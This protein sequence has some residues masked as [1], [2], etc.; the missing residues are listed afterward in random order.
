[1]TPGPRTVPMRLHATRRVSFMSGGCPVCGF[2][3]SSVSPADAAVALRTFPRRYR[4]VLVPP[5]EEGE[6]KDPAHR[7]GVDGWSAIAHAAWAADA[8]TTIAGQLR[9]VL[10]VDHPD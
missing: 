4:A 10:V 6:H 9:Q 3:G 1:M 8:I 2:D 5:Q 7:P